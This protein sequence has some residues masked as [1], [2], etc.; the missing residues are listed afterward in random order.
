[1]T[2][3]RDEERREQQQGR[4]DA[5]QRCAYEHT[6]QEYQSTIKAGAIFNVSVCTY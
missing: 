2:T 5:Q 1:M 4:T 3:D 6:N